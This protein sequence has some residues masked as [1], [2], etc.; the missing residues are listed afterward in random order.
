MTAAYKNNSVILLLL[1]VSAAFDTVDHSILLSRLSNFFG[2]KE[3]STNVKSYLTSRTQ[4]VSVNNFR[5]S[6]RLL[7]RDI[8]Q[9]S[10]LG[11][12]LYSLYTSSLA[13]IV[14]SYDIE[15]HFMHSK[16]TVFMKRLLANP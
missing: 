6:Q 4:F 3:L 7:E 12:L 11:P 16:V 9:G 10:V 5:S 14:K 15:Y 2:V 8:L 13:D 1:D